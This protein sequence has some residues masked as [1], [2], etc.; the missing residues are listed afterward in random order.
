[1]TA[2][3]CIQRITCLLAILLVIWTPGTEAHL[4][5]ESS[6]ANLRQWDSTT[7][8][9]EEFGDVEN[10]VSKLQSAID[11]IV[12]MNTV[13]TK[14]MQDTTYSK[15]SWFDQKRAKLAFRAFQGSTGL[16]TSSEPR[17]RTVYTRVKEVEDFLTDYKTKDTKIVCGDAHLQKWYILRSGRMVQNLNEKRKPKVVGFQYYGMSPMLWIFLGYRHS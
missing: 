5:D 10:A 4:I 15:G 16:R 1:M 7:E 6:C 17:W 11:E 2:L 9:I 13:S 14:L 8:K 12:K 3:G